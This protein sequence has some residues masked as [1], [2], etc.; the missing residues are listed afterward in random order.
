MTS[1]N[2]YVFLCSVCLALCLSCL[3]ACLCLS[4][5]LVCLPVFVSRLS[6]LVSLCLCVSLSLS[7]C[8]CGRF[9]AFEL[10]RCVK[11]WFSRKNVKFHPL[12]QHYL[13]ND[14]FCPL[15]PIAGIL[16]GWLT[17]WGGSCQ[18]ALAGS[19]HRARTNPDA[20]RPPSL[21]IIPLAQQ[22]AAAPTAVPAANVEAREGP[23]LGGGVHSIVPS[24]G[25]TKDFDN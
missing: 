6:L 19:L 8:L 21:N 22:Q 10:P 7:L 9:V 3:S 12:L 18:N 17:G 20:K 15:P 11:D 5:C 2:H 14:S 4:L 24:A 1:E 25:R 16:F 13:Q 23:K